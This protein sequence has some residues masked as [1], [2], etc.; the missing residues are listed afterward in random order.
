M[1]YPPYFYVPVCPQGRVSAPLH[2]GTD[3]PLADT[4]WADTPLDRHPPEQTLPWA[5]TPPGRHPLGRHPS[6]QT[7]PWADTPRQTLPWADTPGSHPPGSHPPP[8]RHPLNSACWDMV[9]K[10]AVRIPL[11][12]ILVFGNAFKGLSTAILFL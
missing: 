11:E 3:N 12:C 4:P 8:G 10:R 1:K 9:N 7:P 5:D 6:R 2:V